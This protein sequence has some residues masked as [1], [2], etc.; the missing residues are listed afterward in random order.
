MSPSPARMSI[1]DLLGSPRRMCESLA[2]GALDREVIQRAGRPYLDRYYLAGWKPG[3]PRGPAVYLHHF[4][5]SDEPGLYHSHPWAWSCSVILVGGYRETRC[6]GAGQVVECVY[7]P[8]EINVILVDDRHRIELLE[9]DCWTLFLAGDYA[10]PWT[11]GDC[12]V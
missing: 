6:V 9:R 4:L 1:D 11:F 5:D 7:L 10:R 2:A 12:E 8:G 3:R